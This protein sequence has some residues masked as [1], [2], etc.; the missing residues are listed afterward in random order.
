MLTLG[1]LNLWGAKQPNTRFEKL[2]ASGFRKGMLISVLN[3]L[4]IPFWVG[5]TAY[6][7]SMGWIQLNDGPAML[8]YALGVSLGTF[9]LLLL[10]ALLGKKIAFLFQKESLVKV[11]PG[12]VFLILGLYSLYLYFT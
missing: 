3:P 2:R 11:L 9:F 10:I 4:S 7:K 1:I 12:I 8:T 5:V 6:A